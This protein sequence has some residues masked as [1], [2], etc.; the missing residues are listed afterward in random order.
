MHMTR[1]SG[2]DPESSKT[3]L[4]SLIRRDDGA[5][6][7][8]QL[9]ML[10]R[11][12]GAVLLLL[13]SAHAAPASL[14]ETNP[15]NILLLYSYGHG[16][17]G[18]DVFDDSLV[19]ALNAGGVVTNNLFFEYLDLERNQATPNY[20]PRL[21][22]MLKLKYAG[23]RIDLVITIQQPALS[24][25]LREGAK[26][27]AGAPAITLQAPMPTATE[28]GQRRFISQLASFDMKGT[29]QR[30]LELFPATRRVVVVSGSSEADKK[31]AAAAEIIATA[32]KGKLEFEYTADLPLDAMLKR[33]ASLPPDTLILFTQYN[34]DAEGRVTVAYEVEGMIVK[35]ANAPVFGLYDFNLI[36]GGIGGSVIGVRKLGENTGRLALDILNGKFKLSEPVTSVSN[37][38]IAMFDW[39][40]IK[41]WGGDPTRLSGYPVFVN[42]VPTFWEQYKLYVIGLTLFILAQSLLIAALLASRQRRIATERSLQES[43]ESLAITLHSIG[44]AVIATDP[45]GRVTRMNP[46][47]ERLSGWTLT[48]ATGRPLTEVFRIVNAGTR[49]TVADPVQLVMAHGQVVGLANH[50]VLLAKDGREYQIADSAAPIR[51]AAGNIVGVVLVFSDVTEKYRVE[52]ALRDSESTL[53]RFF[54]LVPD[55]TCIASTDGHLLKINPAWSAVLG[56][57]EHEILAT[58]FLEL[59]HPD[60]RD[61][62]MAEVARQLAGKATLR[63][64]NRYRC[65]DGSYRWLEWRATPAQDNSLLFASARDI[66]ER[67]SAEAAIR[68]LN[69]ELEQRVLART[70]ELDAANRF[71][72]EAK[73]AADAANIAK[74]AFLANMSHEIRTPMNGILGMANI[75]R[76]EGVS[77]QQAKRLDTIDTATQ[78]LLSVINNILDI[79]KIEAGKFTLEQAPI[80]VSSVL[81]NVSSI[82]SERARAKGLR[83]L[84]ENEHVPHNLTGDPARLQQA[85]LN[86]AA[87]AVKFSETGSVIL[88][89]L[90]Q[91]ETAGAVRVRFEVQD[92]GIGIEAASLPRLFG[93]FEQADNSMTRKYGGTGLGLAITRRL[94][95]LMGGEAGAESTPGVGSIFWFTVILKK[96]ETVAE[97]ATAPET[98]AESQLLQHYAGRRI[99]VVD[100]EPINREVA[101]MQLEAVGLLVDTAE[102]GAAALI[103]AQTSAYDAILMDMQMPKLNGVD[104]TRQLRQMPGYQHT[105]IIAMTANVFAEDKAACFEAGM[106]DFLIKPFDPDALYA[107]LLHGLTSAR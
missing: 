40:Q 91:E 57:S 64:I 14:P 41:R 58:P 38:V 55:M 5:T 89:A 75:M 50:T 7:L 88:R 32:W 3:P 63:F 87:N 11:A 12:A 52:M 85:L 19:G 98:D 84:I 107:I 72:T 2:L 8:Q 79:S 15:K 82:L 45:A 23:R 33:V 106:N 90:K 101:Q 59:I 48:D 42:R 94:A 31:M 26:I 62:T 76:R 80:T 44:D 25:L 13:C 43:E 74:S 60:D 69:T 24:F 81:A 66:T 97:S 73:I 49:E 77:P 21:L 61:A 27:A 22:A 102:D 20:R 104:A 29:L 28:A 83:L 93:A 65:K 1:H 78:H 34:R 95:E 39:T 96:A 37:D 99:L 9:K 30:A 92:N 16:G 86:Y 36:N 71:L 53:N 18:M 56:Y 51:N 6:L 46:T 100:D 17:R 68:Q 105:P 4:D 67:M 35:A 103:W 47:A 70:A 10:I 54:A